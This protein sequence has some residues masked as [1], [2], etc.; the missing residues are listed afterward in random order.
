MPHVTLSRPDLADP[1]FAGAW[2]ERALAWGASAFLS[3]AW[4]GCLAAERYP[5]P[6]LA[7]VREGGGVI[8]MALLNRRS[9]ALT[10]RFHLHESGDPALDAVFTEHNGVLAAPGRAAAAL[11]AILQALGGPITRV[12]LSGTD[13]A[14]LAAARGAG[15]VDRLH[16]RTAPF[17]RLDPEA[18]FIAGLS[19]NTRAQLRRSDRSYAAAGPL[20]VMRAATTGQA[21]DWLDR[22]VSLHRATWAA[23]GI[24]SGFLGPHVQRFH[25]ALIERGVPDGTVE[26]LHVTAGPRS[27]GFLLNLRAAGRSAAYQS[28]FDYAGAAPHEKPGLTSHAAAAEQ[29]RQEGA[30]EYDFLAGD[31]RYKRSLANETR[32]MHWFGWQQAHSLPGL[33]A[34]ARRLAGR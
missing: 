23:R 26:L 21:L 3:W 31:A 29:A 27:I 13:D 18:P 17:A 14:A 20:A 34:A 30:A 4:V 2:Q 16:T 24:A 28:G 6:V 5:D 32:S 10:R 8:G 7:E 33:A 9:G 11:S 12:V 19:R 1:A 25:R 22:L 15:V